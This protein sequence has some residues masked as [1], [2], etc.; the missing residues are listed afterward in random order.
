MKKL[1]VLALA[2]LVALLIVAPGKQNSVEAVMV[3]SSNV[4][5]VPGPCGAFSGAGCMPTSGF[6]GGY[7]PSFTN[8][9]T[10][11]L[12]NVISNYD[13]VVLLQICNIGSWL[14]DS[15]WRDALDSWIQAGGKLII[16]DS[17]A[18]GTLTLDYSNFVFP[19]STN[20]PCQCGSNL[21]TLEIVEDN[22]LS[23]NDPTSP[24]YIDVAPIEQNTDAVGDASVMLTQDSHWKGDMKAKNTLGFEGFTHTYGEYGSG[25]IIY[26][27]LDSDNIGS[28]SGLQK[29]WELEL[30]QQWDPSDLPGGVP[31]AGGRKVLFI[32]G[33]GSEKRCGHPEDFEDRV[34]WMSNQ[35]EARIPG[36]DAGDFLYYKYTSPYPD[37]STCAGDYTRVDSCWSLD[38]TYT[39]AFWRRTVSGGGQAAR[40]ASYLRS[41][42]DNHSG[43]SISII[44][45]SQGGVLATYAVKEKLSAAYQDRIEAIVTLDSPLRGINSLGPGVLRTFAGCANNDLRLDSSFDMVPGSAVITRINDGDTP[46]TKLY[47]VDADPG[48]QSLPRNRC[49]RFPLIDDAH[50]DA[51]WSA[52]HISV[53]A[54]THSDIWDGCFVQGTFKSG[55]GCGGGALPNEGIRLVRFAACAVA[56]LDADCSGFANQPE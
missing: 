48:C 42:L 4:A 26:N 3:S 52:E 1:I 21:G 11:N 28:S 55:P 16:Y 2:F 5:L 38:D 54:D 6:S 9:A 40:L 22:T 47:T 25:L 29:I 56:E 53:D 27:G 45:H 17:D 50:S 49:T 39:R 8:V 35:L 32:Q 24:Y 30:K 51:S 10:S 7:A 14:G 44:T 37:D 23:S 18:C 46:S 13:T 34:G 41:Y 33:I 15:T 36:L 20:N 19:F 43:I 31:V 12:P